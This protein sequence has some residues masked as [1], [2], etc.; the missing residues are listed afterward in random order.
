MA[1]EA[2]RTLYWLARASEKEI[3]STNAVRWRERA[4]EEKRKLTDHN[5]AEKDGF[6][7]EQ[8]DELV[9]LSVR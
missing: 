4:E 3:P 5:M 7:E 9:T 6:T 2:A 1:G 8:Y